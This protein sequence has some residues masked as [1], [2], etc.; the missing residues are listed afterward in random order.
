VPGAPQ[1]TFSLRNRRH[2]STTPPT[3]FFFQR[4]SEPYL[5][6]YRNYDPVVYQAAQAAYEETRR[7][8]F[9]D[10]KSQRQS[11]EVF[12]NHWSR[13]CDQHLPNDR[14]G[15]ELAAGIRGAAITPM[16]DFEKVRSGA[17]IIA[18]LE[19]NGL[20]YPGG[21]TGHVLP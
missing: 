3:W 18:L 21:D 16:I 10:M 6:E 17:E 12:K 8:G 15:R 9:E 1:F 13:C 19:R 11:I 4:I 7:I 14:F 2:E 20:R 5:A